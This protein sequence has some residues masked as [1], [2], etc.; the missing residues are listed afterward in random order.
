MET[1]WVE[2]KKY[3]VICI[4]PDAKPVAEISLFK[5]ESPSLT[6]LNV[7]EIVNFS[8]E[9]PFVQLR[10]KG[11]SDTLH[12]GISIGC[13]LNIQRYVKISCCIVFE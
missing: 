4:A 7:T 1:P 10:T 8:L 5:G 9:W 2:G 6:A 13:N 12:S 3:T 11:F